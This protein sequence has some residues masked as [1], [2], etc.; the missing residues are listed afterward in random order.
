MTKAQFY[1]TPP[2]L[3]DKLLR[4]VAHDYQGRLYYP[5]DINTP[6]TLEP[7]A[8]MGALIEAIERADNDRN[9]RYHNSPEKYCGHAIEV[10]S[11]RAATLK[12]KGYTVVAD[13][14]LNFC[15][16][17]QYKYIIMNPPF[18]NGARHIL[19][20]I[21]L[22]TPEGTL[23]AIV[24]AET[25]KNP[26]DN[27]RKE[28]VSKLDEM[29][30]EIEYVEAA[31]ANAEHKTNVEVALIK[32][33]APEEKPACFTLDNF[34]QQIKDEKDSLPE[35]N[36][37]IRHGEIP[38]LI[39]RYKAETQAAIA[40][41]Q[42]IEGLNRIGLATAFT[43]HINKAPGSSDK[44]SDKTQIIRRI[45][46]DYWARLLYS[47]ELNSLLTN[48]TQEEYRKNLRHMA[49]YEFNERNILQLKENLCKNLLNNMEIA[50]MDVW[51]TFTSKY[52]YEDYSKNIHYY[53]GWKTNKAYKCN[54]KIILPYMNAYHYGD[55][56][57]D[58]QISRELADIEKVFNY[59]DCGRTDGED[60]NAAIK[61]AKAQGMTRFST[62]YFDITLYKKGTAHL[63]FKDLELLKKF[64]LYCG[65]KQNWLPDS[66]GTKPYS[67][68]SAEEKDVVDAFEG[69]ASYQNTYAKQDF[70]LP[71]INDT[72]LQLLSA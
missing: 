16:L 58:Y 69:K 20:A 57:P 36:A 43:C 39:D 68:L 63:V 5:S 48:K 6:E 61:T 64:N 34:T 66:Y 9:Q 40:L 25:I 31:F 46:Y 21:D 56:M 37:L 49:D 28:L 1:P 70:Y 67:D 59:L 33:V 29:K 22:L 26:C 35:T 55:Y 3:A 11:D 13:N 65:R 42:E 2:E 27:I 60:M 53:N 71:T 10:N 51:E 32:A 50:I 15:P 18:N 24:N 23:L 30:A 52:S 45:N 41:Y 8:G 72:G 17:Y 38:A 62:K 14:F 4:M 7:S 12:G 19:H 47:K 54:K 44:L